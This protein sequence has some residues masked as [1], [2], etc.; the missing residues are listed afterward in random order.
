MQTEGNTD[1]PRNDVDSSA[2]DEVARDPRPP[3]KSDDLD[4]NGVPIP[5]GA[6]PDSENSH[7]NIALARGGQPGNRNRVTHG[8]RSWLRSCELPPGTRYLRILERDMRVELRKEVQ[9]KHKKV[10]LLQET[11][12][13]YAVNSE[14]CRRLYVR[15]AR[16]LK[17]KPVE[18]KPADG[19]HKAVFETPKLDEEARMP[20]FAEAQKCM[21]QRQDAIERLQL[22]GVKGKGGKVSFFDRLADDE[23]GA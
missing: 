5:P 18:V 17:A 10:T 12:I 8:V 13:D 16:L 9:K 22:D 23:E 21:R 20:L 6:P 19:L 11:W 4:T 7:S 3:E 1:I 2:S 14:I 15:A